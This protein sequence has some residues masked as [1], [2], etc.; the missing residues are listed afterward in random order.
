MRKHSEPAKK[1]AVE[2]VYCPKCEDKPMLLVAVKPLL[3]RSGVEE[4]HYRC[5]E[6]NAQDLR[7]SGQ[8]RH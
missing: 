1:P 8:S 4:F 2:I 5:R 3:F 7:I 6:C